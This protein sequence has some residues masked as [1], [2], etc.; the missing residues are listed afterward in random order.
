MN[1]FRMTYRVFHNFNDQYFHSSSFRFWH[2]VRLQVVH[3]RNIDQGKGTT[4]E[5]KSGFNRRRFR[6]KAEQHE[7]PRLDEPER[8]EKNY[9]RQ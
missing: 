3:K 8:S 6:H 1:P 7:L 2:S 4:A 5:H 9:R